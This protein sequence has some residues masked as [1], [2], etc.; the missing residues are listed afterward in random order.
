MRVYVRDY[1][2]SS[3]A[4]AIAVDSLPL[5]LPLPQ[6]ASSSPSTS[7][8]HSLCFWFCLCRDDTYQLHPKCK[9]PIRYVGTG[10]GDVDSVA[11]LDAL[12]SKFRFRLKRV[13]YLSLLFL[14]PCAFLQTSSVS[15][16]SF[17]LDSAL[18]GSGSDQAD[19]V[20]G[21]LVRGGWIGRANV[22]S[23]SYIKLL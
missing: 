13:H 22:L 10:V 17:A 15:S 16:I 21:L 9:Q 23:Y 14:F 11:S 18:Y 1:F 12:L 3:K 7:L 19:I 5:P 8:L 4:L 6:S 2:H 20:G